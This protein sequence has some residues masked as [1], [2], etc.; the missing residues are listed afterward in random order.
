MSSNAINKTGKNPIKL[1][2]H[3]NKKHQLK[4]FKIHVASA[5]SLNIKISILTFQILLCSEILLI[6]PS[7]LCARV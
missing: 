4:T 5:V 1:C 6:P 3:L 2:N 7:R